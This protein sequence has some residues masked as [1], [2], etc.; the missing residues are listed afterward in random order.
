MN[1]AHLLLGSNEGDRRLWLLKAMEL[2]GLF[3][4]VCKRSSIYETAAWGKED[5][6]DFLNMVIEIDTALSSEELL[7][8]I[9]RTERDLGRQRE[10]KWG[11]RTLDIDILFFNKEIINTETLRIPHPFLQERRF[12]LEPLNEIAGDFIHP[13]FGTTVKELLK[14]CKDPLVVRKF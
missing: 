12:T 9:Q 7:H 14:I 2:I 1:K 4:T 3:A 5:Q 11:Q 8:A 10:V 13:E 6:P